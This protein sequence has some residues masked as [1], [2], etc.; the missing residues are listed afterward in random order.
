MLRIGGAAVIEE[1]ADLAGHVQRAA[2]QG[3]HN[4]E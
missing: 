3:L 4:Y 1:P 2:A